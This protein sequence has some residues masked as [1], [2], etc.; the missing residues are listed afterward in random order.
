MSDYL[1]RLIQRSLGLAP[2]ITPLIA[3]IHAPPDQ[4]LSERELPPVERSQGPAIDAPSDQAPGERPETSVTFERDRLA[5]TTMVSSR[6]AP[7]EV[8]VRA[9]RVEPAP[10]RTQGQP[11]PLS[12]PPLP[13]RQ[14]EFSIQKKEDRAYPA[15]S[16]PE[17]P[18]QQ[19]SSTPP[20]EPM[21]TA[22]ASLA[23]PPA[24]PHATPMLTQ[25]TSSTP[26]VERM[27]TQQAAPAAV[28]PEIVIPLKSA[29]SPAIP[30]SESPPEE[31]PLLPRTPS[32]A[33]EKMARAVLQPEVIRALKPT[34]SPLV[35]ALESLAMEPSL[36]PR[37]TTTAPRKTNETVVQPEAISP[38]KPAESPLVPVRQPSSNEPAVIHVTIG[39][40]EVRA[41]M[42]PVATPKAEAPAAPG[43]SLEDYLKQRNGSRS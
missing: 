8:P 23:D 24:L 19:T 25:Q 2:L 37:T 17:A 30:S 43:L 26:R 13:A 22:A 5:A 10:P 14:A 9:G 29:T 36:S 3:P 40:I 34:A 35:P 15:E 27:V 42:Q 11:P 18:A 39:R 38:L 31:P 1:T 12:S 28:Q 20:V 4:A 6:D 21:V 7:P 32:I 33:P 41:I 16:R